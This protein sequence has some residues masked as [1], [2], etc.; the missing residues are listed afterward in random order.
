MEN[1]EIYFQIKP[2]GSS[3]NIMCKYCYVQPFRN[4][5][6]VT[7][8]MQSVV[9]ENVIRKCIKNSPSPTFS[10]HGGE[11][12]LAGIS[13]FKEAVR[14]IEKYLIPKQN[15]SNL[16]QTNATLIDKDFAK[17]FKEYE[18][19]VS[20][21]LDGPENV[22]NLYR[23]NCLG[24]GSFSTTMKG[25]DNLR[26]TGIEP[27]VIATVTKETLKYA[28]KAFNFLVGEGF[29][30]IKFSPVYDTEA[31]VFS[32]DSKEWFEY[33]RKIF[34]SWVELGNPEIQVRE[35]DEIIAWIRKE[36]ISMCSSN[37]SCSKWISVD[38]DGNLYPCEYLRSKYSY[39]N[40]V[41]SEISE[42]VS[43]ARHLDFMKTLQVLHDECQACTFQKLC[44][45]GCPATRVENGEVSSSGLYVYCQQRKMLYQEISIE[46]EKIL[47]SKGGENNA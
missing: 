12:T 10:W 21:S 47:S 28:K 46:F 37:S 31:N 13:F 5:E 39:G 7:K 3:C 20:V 41:D 44:G 6:K 23:T 34:Y 16:I 11:P 22:H 19:A 8:L 14:L 42:I 4:Q 24:K 40:I 43:S 1:N 27:T 38:P 25:I 30:L 35:I 9:L 29:K 32:I 33:L 36:N 15:A 26:K 18:F 2:V 45:N 17:F